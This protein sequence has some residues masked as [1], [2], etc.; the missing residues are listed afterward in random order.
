MM[1]WFQLTI[2]LTACCYLTAVATD[3]N[4]NLPNLSQM[5]GFSSGPNLPSL[6]NASFETDVSFFGSGGFGE[7]Y[8]LGLQ[9]VLLIQIIS[10]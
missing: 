5:S 1:N 4:N 8:E 3:S 9:F 10:N 7:Y 6:P 2:T